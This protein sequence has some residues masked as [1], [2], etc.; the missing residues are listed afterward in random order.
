MTKFG[1]QLILSAMEIKSVGTACNYISGKSENFSWEKAIC[2][3]LGCAVA[4]EWKCKWKSEYI[5]WIAK[6]GGAQISY[7]FIASQL[8]TH[9]SMYALWKTGYFFHHVSIQVS[10]PPNW[11]QTATAILTI[12]S[13]L[14]AIQEL[15]NWKL[16]FILKCFVDETDRFST[17]FWQFLSQ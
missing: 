10:L 15:L 2:T 9:T 8:S 14:S 11:T 1:E 7:Q 3:W 6:G 17:D 16:V 4:R 5:T 12:G 13:P